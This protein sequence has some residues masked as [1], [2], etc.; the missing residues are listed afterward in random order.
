MDNHFFPWG[1]KFWVL[2]RG[3]GP[4]LR[5]FKSKFGFLGPAWAAPFVESDGWLLKEALVFFSMDPGSNVPFSSDAQGFSILAQ[6]HGEEN[7]GLW[8]TLAVVVWLLKLGSPMCRVLACEIVLWAWLPPCEGAGGFLW[9]SFDQS[10]LPFCK[11][12]MS[13]LTSWLVVILWPADSF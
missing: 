2:K 13:T 11:Y 7:W 8:L 6:N 10:F 5:R 1:S 3:V 4:L 12:A 9:F